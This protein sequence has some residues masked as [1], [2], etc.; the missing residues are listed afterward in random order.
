VEKPSREF[1]F[2]FDE[3]EYEYDRHWWLLLREEE[4][5]R[6]LRRISLCR[7]TVGGGGGERNIIHLL[8]PGKPFLWFSL[9]FVAFFLFSY[10]L[11]ISCNNYSQ[12]CYAVDSRDVIGTAR[13]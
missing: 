2:G 10:I 1:G 9:F 12:F 4:E 3:D 13:G 5:E 7:R 6:S 8:P 11:V